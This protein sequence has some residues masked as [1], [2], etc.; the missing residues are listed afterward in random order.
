MLVPGD[1]ECAMAALQCTQQVRQ[2]LVL[3]RLEP[4]AFQPFQ[5]DADG[6]VVAVVATAPARGAGMP[7]AGIAGHELQQR[8]IAAHESASVMPAA[9]KS[10]GRYFPTAPCD[11]TGVEARLATPVCASVRAKSPPR[12]RELPTTCTFALGAYTRPWNAW[13][14]TVSV[15]SSDAPM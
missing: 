12:N 2:A 3:H 13:L 14:P 11:A 1:I 8:A 7:G 6:V 10:D 4:P 9:L 5:L 15:T